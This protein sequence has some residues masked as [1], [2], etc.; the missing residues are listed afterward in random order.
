MHPSIHTFTF[1]QEGIQKHYNEFFFEFYHEEPVNIF[2]KLYFVTIM[3]PDRLHNKRICHGYIKR[4][5]YTKHMFCIDE[6]RNT[7]V[8]GHEHVTE[9]S[10]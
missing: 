8:K 3:P 10:K 2:V 1:I 9:I 4:M 5:T 7:E 6:K